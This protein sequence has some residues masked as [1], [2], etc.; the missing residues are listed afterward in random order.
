MQHLSAAKHP[1]STKLVHSWLAD[2]GGGF[3]TAGEGGINVDNS[4]SVN[5]GYSGLHDITLDAQTVSLYSPHSASQTVDGRS[6]TFLYRND[7]FTVT[8]QNPSH[9]STVS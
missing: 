1:P 5:V 9:C 7:T 8:P 2:S 6:V 4:P 3:I